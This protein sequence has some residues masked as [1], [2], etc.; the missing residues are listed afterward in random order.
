MS[1]TTV[2]LARI[3]GKAEAGKELSAREALMS[4]PYYIIQD[5]ERKIE[6]ARRR[7]AT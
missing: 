4:L 3:I 6:E 7:Y 2:V 5:V 1:E